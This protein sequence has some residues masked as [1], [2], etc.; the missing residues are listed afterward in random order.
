MFC[1]QCGSYNP[2]HA[3][4]CSVCGYR[5]RED[6]DSSGMIPGPSMPIGGGQPGSVPLAQGTPQIGQGPY[7][8]GTPSPYAP[9][10]V[11]IAQHINVP[12]GSSSPLAPR[13]AIRLP[14]TDP[15][16]YPPQHPGPYPH[17]GHPTGPI[18]GHPG[19][20]TSPIQGH[21]SHPGQPTGPYEGHPVHHP[22]HPGH[23]QHTGPQHY[24]HSPQYPQHLQQVGPQAYAPSNHL[25]PPMS[26]KIVS[27]GV[28]TAGR[29]SRRALF[30]LVAGGTVA[31]AAGGAAV[32]YLT[33]STPEK[34]IS[35]FL[36]AL[37]NRDGQ[38]AFN[39]LSTHLQSTTDEQKYISTIRAWGG[40]I[41][42]YSISNVQ[43]NGNNA[44]ADVSVTAAFFVT[45][46]YSVTLVKENGTWKIDGGNLLNIY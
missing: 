25:R 31:V 36:D 30:L 39:Q 40:V 27:T 17:P 38:G 46:S 23:F 1:I 4:F 42:S 34:T 8:Q 3:K 15:R 32:V 2:D 7:V 16:P 26:Q 29:L 44:T 41:T 20:S 12:P 9:G 43:E 21:P 45:F 37:K 6:R 13:E 22:S 11:P 5:G 18:Q 24:A 33:T 35:A 28:K 10:S 14:Q 19:H